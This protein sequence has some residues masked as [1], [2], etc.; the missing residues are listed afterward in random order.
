MVGWLVGVSN[1][2]GLIILYH[3]IVKGKGK[4]KEKRKKRKRKK[5]KKQG[6]GCLK[7]SIIDSL[8]EEDDRYVI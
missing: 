4:G 3:R 2:F 6:I 8:H 1:D 5:K 7:S